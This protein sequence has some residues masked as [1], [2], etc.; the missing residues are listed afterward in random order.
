MN[1][2]DI[3]YGKSALAGL[4]GGLVMAA[5]AMMLTALLGMGLFAMPK[6]IGGLIFGAQAAMSGGAMLIAVG[7]MLHMML[8]A[9]FGLLYGVIVNAV[10][11]EFWITGLAFGMALWIVNFY[12]VG[13]VL[14]GARMMAQSEPV[15]LAV[16]THAVFGLVTAWFAMA[17]SRRSAITV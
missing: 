7:L 6:M 11:H 8:S 1:V 10:T 12:L 17:S 3:S 5:M 14:P 2:Q 16:M 9:M 15:W 4:V 13:L